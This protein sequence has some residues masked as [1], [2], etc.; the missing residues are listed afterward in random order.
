MS[1]IL[2]RQKTPE[3][4]HSFPPWKERWSYSFDNFMA[5]GTTALI[6]G[7][8]GITLVLIFITVFNNKIIFQAEA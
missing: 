5:R 3:I 1:R 2:E 8:E 4:H 7:L 6:A